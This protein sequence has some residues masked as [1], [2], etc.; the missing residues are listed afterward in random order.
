[1]GKEAKPIKNNMEVIVSAENLWK[2]YNSFPAVK[3]VDFQIKK[4]EIYAF[5]GPNGAGK[6][7]I[8]KMITCFFPPSKGEL[9]VFGLDVRKEKRKIKRMIGF[10][11]QEINLDPD[12]SVEKNLYIYARY[13]RI[14]KKEVR[15]KVNELLNLFKLENKRE[16]VIEHLS[17]GQ[18]KRLLIA[19][20][21]INE[22]ELLIFD[23]PTTGLDPQARHFIWDKIKEI[24]KK[25]MTS[26]LTT[27]YMEE[28]QYLCDRVSIVHEGKIIEEGDPNFLVNKHIGKRVVEVEVEREE[29]KE[30]RELIRS[31]PHEFHRG[32]IYIYLKDEKFPYYE[33]LRKFVVRDANLE[34]VFLKLTGRELVER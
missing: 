14:K 3:G 21:L 32:K 34:D 20:A 8:V 29:E 33:K 16:E 1:L 23:E 18:K 17:G 19:R 2:Y 9:E 28:A 5:L 27:H 4:G 10:A 25:G 6:T 30:V 12:F 13:F 24:K 11:P 7:T 26:I 15:K 31:F 22:P